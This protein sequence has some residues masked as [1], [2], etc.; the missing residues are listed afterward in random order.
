LP[1]DVRALDPEV[2]VMEVFEWVLVPAVWLLAIM[3]A[4]RWLHEPWITHG[5][6]TIAVLFFA[7]VAPFTHARTDDWVVLAAFLPALPL[8][9]SLLMWRRNRLLPWIIVVALCPV[10]V[11]AAIWGVLVLFAIVVPRC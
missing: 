3:C 6:T 9:F 2:P 7:M 1:P 10:L 11:A 5:A 4:H 8:A